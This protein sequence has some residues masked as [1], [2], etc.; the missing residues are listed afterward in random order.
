MIFGFSVLS[1]RE[2]SSA[3]HAARRRCSSGGISRLRAFTVAA[4]TKSSRLDRLPEYFRDTVE[5]ITG[6]VNFVLTTTGL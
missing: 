2:R 1:R 5:W 6:F 4:S 3:G